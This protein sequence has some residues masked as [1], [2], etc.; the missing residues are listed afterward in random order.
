MGLFNYKKKSIILPNLIPFYIRGFY[1]DNITGYTLSIENI[2]CDTWF[3]EFSSLLV[4]NRVNNFLP[5][6]RLSDGEYSFVCGNQPPIKN[7]FIIQFLSNVKFYI[8]NLKPSLNFEAGERGIYQSGK[9]SREEINEFLPKY[10]NNLKDL[11]ENGIL[12]LHLTYAK[13]PFQERFH[14]ALKKTFQKHG[15]EI[16]KSNYFPFYFVYAF[17]QTDEFRQYINLK[18]VLFITGSN[19]QKINKVEKKFIEFGVYSVE[20]Y[21][22]STNRSLFDIIDLDNIKT[23]GVDVCLIAAGIGKPNIMVQLKPLKCLCIDVGYMF[24]VWANEELAF[25]RPWCSKNFK[26]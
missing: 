12:A 8:N 24:E 9:Y 3:R 25:N 1:N 2:D 26:F 14:H 5:I 19:D 21:K 15:I 18:K 20:I 17:L 13:V 11:S 4:S 16:N 22:I 7:T 10:L 6:C 23:K